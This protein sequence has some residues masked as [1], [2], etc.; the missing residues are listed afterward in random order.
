MT[1]RWAKK[2][3]GSIFTSTECF[4]ASTIPE[5]SDVILDRQRTGVGPSRILTVGTNQDQKSAVAYFDNVRAVYRN[6]IA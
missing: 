2:S 4:C 6:R 3:C 1:A 5:D